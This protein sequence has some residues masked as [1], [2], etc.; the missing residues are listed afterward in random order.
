MMSNKFCQIHHKYI[1]IPR[2]LQSNTPK[3]SRSMI[4]CKTLTQLMQSLLYIHNNPL[5]NILLSKNIVPC[6]FYSNVCLCTC[7]AL[8]LSKILSFFYQGY[9]S[10][11]IYS[12]LNIYF[13]WIRLTFHWAKII[14]TLYFWTSKEESLYFIFDLTNFN[15]STK[16]ISI[17]KQAHNLYKILLLWQWVQFEFTSYG[18]LQLYILVKL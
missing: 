8:Y 3:H 7:H 18:T 14:V 6:T 13:N 17:V 11:S 1:I 9:K 4:H 5:C 2:W 16:S 15:P 12:I 10:Y